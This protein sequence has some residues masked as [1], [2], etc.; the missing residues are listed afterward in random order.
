MD[1]FER[2]ALNNIS[3]PAEDTLIPLPDLQPGQV[4]AFYSRGSLRTGVVTSIGRKNV[5][6]LY[7]TE[8]AVR[9][10]E[11]IHAYHL[12][13][14]PT[15]TE[16]QV[17]EVEAKNYDYYVREIGPDAQYYGP[18]S[19][20]Q[21]DAPTSY[22]EYVSEGKDAYIQRK[23]DARLA[24]IAANRERAQQDGPLGY[25]HFT[26]KTVAIDKLSVVA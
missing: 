14:S 12:S 24:E 4:V 7:T 11:K 15:A 23:V 22:Y 8:G 6:V 3:R 16:R 20:G 26:T 25:V 17:R 10:S 1:R 9:E 19:R 13:I 2:I 18:N 21:E 5:K